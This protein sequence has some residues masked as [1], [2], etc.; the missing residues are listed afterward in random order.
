MLIPRCIVLILLSVVINLAA[1]TTSLAQLS[2]PARFEEKVKSSEGVFTLVNLTSEG[3]MLIRDK[4]KYESGKKV[5]QAIA[6]DT[7]LTEKKRVE[8]N[9][10]TRNKMIGYEYCPGQI[11]I[12]FRQGDTEKSDL[13]VVQINL[14]NNE[15]PRYI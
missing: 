12:L 14:D 7:D 15:M 8:F 5:W 4:E 6:L 13:E 9:V 3:L 10:D 11:Y 2:Q 1:A